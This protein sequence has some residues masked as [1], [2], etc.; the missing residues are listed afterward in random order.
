MHLTLEK[1][2]G[3]PGSGVSKD[4]TRPIDKNGMGV[5]RSPVVSLHNREQIKNRC[6]KKESTDFNLDDLSYI[7]QDKIVPEKIKRL[8]KNFKA[9]KDEPIDIY[10]DGDHHL[11]DGHHRFSVFYKHKINPSKV[12][13]WTE[14]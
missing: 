3:G 13:I 5:E 4:N 12:N 9:W 8:E 14:S 1:I 2:A 6:T 10:Y 11:M 7:A